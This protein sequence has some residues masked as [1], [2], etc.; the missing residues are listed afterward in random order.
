AVTHLSNAILREDRVWHMDSPDWSQRYDAQGRVSLMEGGATALMEEAP[1]RLEREGWDAARRA[2]TIT[3]RTWILNGFVASKAGKYETALTLLQDAVTVLQ[4]GAKKWE[5]VSKDDRGI[6]FED[7]FLRGVKRMHLDI[8]CK[9]CMA[10]GSG[11]G[12]SLN[13]LMVS[14]VELL[15]DLEA[16]EPAGPGNAEDLGFAVSFWD[17]PIACTY[18]T[19]GYCNAGL[20][21]GRVPLPEHLG[22][23]M[24]YWYHT[25]FC[26]ERA[27]LRHQE[28]DEKFLYFWKAHIETVWQRERPLRDILPLLSR[29]RKAVPGARQIWG[30]SAAWNTVITFIRPALQY[31]ERAIAGIAEG[32]YT[33]DTP[34]V[35]STAEAIQYA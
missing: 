2:M 6:I 35:R 32:R 17:Y 25:G 4:W 10:L 12:H 16:A 9:A 21:S 11:P 34:S 27:A 13:T 14:A 31:E 15:D 24:E 28:D 33:A 8:Y 23:K 26:Y 29:L 22:E 30:R 18:A 3:V 5:D 1:L 19:L 7:S 20:A